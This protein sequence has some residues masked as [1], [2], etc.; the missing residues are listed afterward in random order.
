MI[1]RRSPSPVPNSWPTMASSGRS[2]ASVSRIIRSTAASASETG[3]RS[4]FVR[5]PS[6][7]DWKCS[8]VMTSAASASCNASLRSAFMIFRDTSFF[9]VIFCD[10]GRA[11]GERTPSFRQRYYRV[12]VPLYDTPLLAGATADRARPYI[13]DALTPLYSPR[14]WR[15]LSDAQPLTY[16]HL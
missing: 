10:C 3:V 7:A 11:G 8:M 1:Q 2:F 5:T 14:A 9:F 13:A 15:E 6:V 16:A 4:D 12:T